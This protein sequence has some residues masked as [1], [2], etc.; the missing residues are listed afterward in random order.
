VEG[1]EEEK[2]VFRRKKMVSSVCVIKVLEGG[3]RCSVFVVRWCPR[4]RGQQ[5]LPKLET[6]SE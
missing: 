2:G 1:N 6:L 3:G 5:T 4:Q